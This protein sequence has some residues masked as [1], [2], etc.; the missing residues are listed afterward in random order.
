MDEIKKLADNLISHISE[1]L[2]VHLK[3]DRASVKWIDDFIERIRPHVDADSI[4]GLSNSI[5]AFLGECFIAN[6]GGGWRQSDDGAWGV[7]FD[8]KNAAYPLAKVQ[9][10]LL[11]GHEDSILSFYTIIPIV[12]DRARTQ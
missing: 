9:K 4:E 3:Y 7:Y 2:G 11:N 8:D 1:A 12:F 10:Q 5:G 6:Y